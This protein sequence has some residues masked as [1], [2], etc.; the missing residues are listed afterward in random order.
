MTCAQA[1]RMTFT[2]GHR[3]CSARHAQ[4]RRRATG[5]TCR[6]TR[7]LTGCL[8]ARRCS[9]ALLLCAAVGMR[10]RPGLHL[11]RSS[12]GQARFFDPRHAGITIALRRSAAASRAG[13]AAGVVPTEGDAAQRPPFR[14][15]QPPLRRLRQASGVGRL[16]SPCAARRRVCRSR[17]PQWRVPRLSRCRVRLRLQVT[18]TGQTRPVRARLWCGLAFE[19]RNGNGGAMRGAPMALSQSHT[20]TNAVHRIRRYDCVAAGLRF[21]PGFSTS[22]KEPKRGLLTVA[23]TTASAT[24]AADSDIG[25]IVRGVTAPRWPARPGRRYRKRS[26]SSRHAWFDLNRN[27]CATASRCATTEYARPRRSRADSSP[28]RGRGRLR[29]ELM[30]LRSSP[31]PAHPA[32][33]TRSD[34]RRQMKRWTATWSSV[35]GVGRHGRARSTWRLSTSA[36]SPASCG[37]T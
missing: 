3:R 33:P 12:A 8:A 14:L 26:T 2:D 11:H 24:R 34:C 7:L 15:A 25:T 36:P 28:A 37:T 23:P 19:D 29:I 32:A 10:R 6:G 30:S 13:I 1:E 18:V 17:H 31:D 9:P 27:G 20:R 4:W 22:Y 5:M 21:V 16:Q 35:G